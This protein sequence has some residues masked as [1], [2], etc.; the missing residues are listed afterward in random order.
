MTVQQTPKPKNGVLVN[1]DMTSPEE[2]LDSARLRGSVFIPRP[3]L[4]Y[5]PALDGIRGI[6]ILI[7]LAAHAKLLPNAASFIGVNTFFVLSGFL[8]TTLL[9]EEWQQ[10]GGI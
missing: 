3:R 5:R 4:G 9:V 2:S 10:F 8:I 7:V 6:C 1:F